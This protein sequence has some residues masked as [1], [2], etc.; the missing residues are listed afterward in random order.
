M[1]A[2]DTPALHNNKQCSLPALPEYKIIEQKYRR[3]SKKKQVP[4][5]V[6][7]YIAQ[8]MACA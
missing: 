4:E 7:E 3:C 6:F 8:L 5:T 1:E 2:L